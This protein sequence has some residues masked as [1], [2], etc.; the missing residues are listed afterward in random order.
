MQTTHM[1]TKNSSEFRQEYQQGNNST[2]NYNDLTILPSEQF[3]DYLDSLIQWIV[4]GAY[5]AKCTALEFQ[6]KHQQWSVTDTF[7]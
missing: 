6:S 2:L 4:C 5:G 3:S 7:S 1:S